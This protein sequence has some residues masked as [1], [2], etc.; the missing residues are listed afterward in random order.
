MNMFDNIC[1]YI[2]YE[3]VNKSPKISIIQMLS[4]LS[5][6]LHPSHLLPSLHRCRVFVILEL[7]GWWRCLWKSV[8]DSVM[9]WR[10]CSLSHQR[11]CTMHA[12]SS[13]RGFRKPRRDRVGHACLLACFVFL[14]SN[15]YSDCKSSCKCCII[16]LKTS[17]NTVSVVS[18]LQNMGCFCQMKTPG[19]ASGWKGAGRWIITCWEMG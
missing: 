13:E 4:M 12:G 1:I 3:N 2:F 8:W 15:I 5:S 19:K 7:A 11:L 14:Y 9:W 17:S 16:W 6:V 18:Q 10:R